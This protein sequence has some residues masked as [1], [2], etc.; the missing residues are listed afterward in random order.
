MKIKGFT[1]IEVLIVAL[2]AGIV[3]TGVAFVTVSSNTVL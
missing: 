1:L 3:G 2:L